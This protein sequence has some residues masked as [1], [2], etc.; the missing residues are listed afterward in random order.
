MK[1]PITILMDEH[2]LIE[3]VL[4]AL[5]GLADRVESGVDVPRREI[6]RFAEFFRGFADRHHHGKEEDRLFVAMEAA[7]MPREGGPI[8]VM[9]HE[10]DEGRA[11]VRALA[12]LGEGEGPL[13][14]DD[15]DAL[16]SHARAFVPLLAAHI[17][18]EDNILYPM[19]RRFLS[20]DAFV[21]LERTCEEYDADTERAAEA[22]RLRAVAGEL[23][24][25]WP[26]PDGPLFS[27][28]CAGEPM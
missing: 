19:A 16:I 27:G 11:H 20:P 10:H 26:A 25:A 8:A 15:R 2:R 9:L 18:K 6:A 28:G 3:K 14:D 1:D 22:D 23:V 13:S 4:G 5:A 24:S 7:G 17:A 21:E 12:A